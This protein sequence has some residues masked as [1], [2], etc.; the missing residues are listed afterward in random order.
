MSSNEH[1]V[2]RIGVSLLEIR[3][4]Y[5]KTYKKIVTDER[6]RGPHV[7]LLLAKS[8]CPVDERD[9]ERQAP[10]NGRPTGT[11]L[12]FEGRGL[13][14]RSLVCSPSPVQEERCSR[15]NNPCSRAS[16]DSISDEPL[17]EKRLKHRTFHLLNGSMHAGSFQESMNTGGHRLPLQSTACLLKNSLGLNEP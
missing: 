11:R 15:S 17:D 2:V 10:R 3:R 1:I 4:I 5:V 8:G 16:C 6:T 9:S 14:F 13:A 12:M 7:P